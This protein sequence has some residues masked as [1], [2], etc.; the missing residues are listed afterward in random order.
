MKNVWPL[1]FPKPKARK[2]HLRKLKMWKMAL[3]A[4]AFVRAR[5]DLFYGTLAKG[6]DDLVPAGPPIWISGDCHGENLGAVADA[7]GKAHLD[8]NDL[9]ETV[10]GYSAHDI[11]R[12]SLDMVV[13]ARSYE[14][15]LGVESVAVV[16]A[17]LQGYCDA[18]LLRSPDRPMA[19][20]E[21]PP[22]LRRL[23]RRTS[24]VD[25][26]KLLDRRVPRDAAGRRRFLHGPRYYP[27]S[28][29]ERAAVEALAEEPS[30]RQL[31][32]SLGD[33]APDTDVALVDAAFRVA[34]TGSLGCFRV[35]LLARV[36]PVHGK[37]VNDEY[38][39]LIDVKEA[40]PASTIR[41][42]D[43]TT[44]KEDA[45]RVVL[46][47]RALVPTLGERMMSTTILGKGVVVRE[48]MPQEQKVSLDVMKKGEAAPIAHHLGSV[49]GRAHARQLGPE[50]A[51]EW[52]RTL[53]P[54]STP[55]NRVPEWLWEPLI[56]LVAVH[57]AS[58][59]RHCAD[60]A[61]AH[62]EVR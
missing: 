19:L 50:Q 36:G 26:T 13:A 58:Y 34:G 33:D 48:L 42:V 40:L 2:E 24:R 20:S 62:P 41:H 47:A 39:R 27:L 3:D 49:L 32:A 8:L 45:E 37:R 7:H 55:A 52:G 22:Q 14:Q 51:A 10:I 59:L 4:H 38:L 43:A 23:L 25:R 6:L 17:V 11:L 46:G 35:A 15:L 9:D 1:G 21:A 31:I 29:E 61:E 53:R 12:L 16:N 44:P 60:F 5:A 30:V 28:R 54:K 57:E 18:L 56:Q